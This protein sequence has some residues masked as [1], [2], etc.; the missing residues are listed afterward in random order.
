[1]TRRWFGTDG[2]R[3]TVGVAPMTPEFIMRLG[4]A[5]GAE[6]QRETRCGRPAV[7]IGKDTRISGYLLEAAL[8]AGLS[9]AGVDSHLVGPLPT[10][11]VAYLT[12]ALRLSAGIVISASHNPYPD[13]GIKF[14]SSGGEKLPDDME[15]RIEARLDDPLA[16]RPA[17]ELGRAFRIPDA[18]G[19]YIEFCKSTFPADL[20]LRGLKLVV[21]CANGAAYH[22]A[23]H[24]FHELG[25]EVIPLFNQPDGLNINCE[26]GATHPQRLAEAVVEQR[27]NAGIALDGDA[28]RLIMV[29]A[30][31]LAV[32]G[33]QLL[34]VIVRHRHATSLVAGVV[35]TLMSNLGLEQSLGRLGIAFERA[36][37]GDRHVLERLRERGWLFGGESSGH[38]I[39]LDSHTTGDGVVSA[40]Q[41]LAAMVRAGASLADLVADMPR[42]PQVL[43]NARLRPGLDWHNHAPLQEAIAEVQSALFGRG[44][45]LV[46]PSGTEPL[47][48]VMVEADD[49]EIAKSSVDGILA[50]LA[51][52]D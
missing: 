11:G 32:D 51:R 12:R 7:L 26:C 14:F 47:L 45:V 40:L 28:D 34:Y 42:F 31:G 35:G 15:S 50:A 22:I 38:I 9:A 2:I 33:D 52:H 8:E 17:G 6:L 20:D 16:C 43:R 37:V 13:N 41:V 29:D 5:F 46:R 3:G 44:R 49:A 4:N 19:R 36:G 23:P 27:A 30:S 48:R 25:A 21:D 10:P 24:V 18:A 39:C 1:V